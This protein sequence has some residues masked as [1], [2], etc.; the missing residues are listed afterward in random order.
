MLCDTCGTLFAFDLIDDKTG[1]LSRAISIL[2]VPTTAFNKEQESSQNV[3]HL[4]SASPEIHK[5][6]IR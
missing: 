1:D 2:L 5:L 4:G 6:Y 3:P